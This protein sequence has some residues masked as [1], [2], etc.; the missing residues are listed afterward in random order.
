MSRLL[1]LLLLASCAA[2]EIRP[3]NPD[4]KMQLARMKE[5]AGSWVT[6]GGSP[7][8]GALVDYRVTAAGNTVEE[9]VFRG[10]DHEMVTMYHLDGHDLVL[11]HYCAMGNQPTMLAGPTSTDGSVTFT[12][13]GGTN[14]EC[15]KDLHM[16]QA[17]FRFEG[18]DR[19]RSAWTLR[20]DGAPGE[21]VTMELARAPAK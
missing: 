15:E 2:A 18:Q 7:G 21:T 12:C 6:T 1:P 4:A 3:M 17:V 20:Q 19:I 11:T 16:H 14:F 10:S 13:I 5:L 9:T 8:P